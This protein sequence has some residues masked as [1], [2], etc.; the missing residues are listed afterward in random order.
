V[1]RLEAAATPRFAQPAE[2]SELIVI[3][4][5]VDRF[6]CE[7]TVSNFEPNSFEIHNER[8]AEPFF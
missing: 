4:G 3:S 1:Y 6:A 2:P 8:K 7:P 5:P